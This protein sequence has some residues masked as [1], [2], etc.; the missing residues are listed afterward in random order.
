MANI[1]IGKAWEETLPFVARE[2]SLLFPVALLF[3]ALPFVILGEMTPKGLADWSAAPNGPMPTV[4]AS[5]WWALVLAVVLV[6]F[7]SLTVIALALRPGIS[8][9][10]ALKLALHRL[11]VLIGTNVLAGFLL[12][13][14]ILLVSIPLIFVMGSVGVMVVIAVLGLFVGMRLALLNPVV[15]DDN[16]VSY[17]H[18]TLPTKLE[19]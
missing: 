3:I 18:L 16:P 14:V 8:V 4:P 2:A 13:A 10:E 19:V 17:T 12:F 9:A 5:Y 6:W 11:P 15:I 1:S 7:G